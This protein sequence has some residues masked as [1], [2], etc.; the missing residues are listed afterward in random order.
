M[1]F[2]A[3]EPLY[4]GNGQT[5]DADFRQRIAHVVEFEWFDYGRE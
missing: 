2:L 3:A 1:A 5:F 4:F